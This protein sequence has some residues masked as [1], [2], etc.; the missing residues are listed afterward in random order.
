[1]KDNDSLHQYSN[2]RSIGNNMDLFLNDGIFYFNCDDTR[3]NY[4]VYL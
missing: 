4:L 1:M 2:V 3:N